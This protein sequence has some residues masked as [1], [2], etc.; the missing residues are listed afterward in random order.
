MDRIAASAVYE[1]EKYT[2]AS[3]LNYLERSLDRQLMHPASYRQMHYLLTMLK[4][5]GENETFSYIKNHVLR[6]KPFP[7]EENT[8]E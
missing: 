1:G 8:E 2:D 6:G 3:A 5:K 4:E 7:W